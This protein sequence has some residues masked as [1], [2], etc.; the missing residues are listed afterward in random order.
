[1]ITSMK[2]ITVYG[3]AKDRK[4]IMESLQKSGCVEI[5]QS[6]ID[7]ETLT[8]VDVSDQ[9][10]QFERYI[11]SAAQAL[12][13]LDEYVPEKTGLFS[14]RKPISL[15]Y[16]TMN[17]EEAKSVGD[18]VFEIIALSK[19][20]QENKINIGRIQAKILALEPWLGL[21]VPMNL[22]H[23]KLTKIGLY[24]L[25][26]EAD[27]EKMD[28][29]LG[30]TAE[31]VYYEL[32]YCTK[33]QSC[34]FMVYLKQEE[35]RVEKAL[36]EAG[37]VQP[38]FSLSHR[39]PQDKVAHLEQDAKI[40][41]DEIAD[42]E[43]RIIEYGQKR[44]SIKLLYD[45]II[46]RRDKYRELSK[47]QLTK[48]AF[49]LT[50]FIPQKYSEKMKQRLEQKAVCEVMLEDL[51][52][53]EEA[54]VLFE[55]NGFAAPVETITKTYAMPSKNDIDPN[56]IMS[57]FYYLFFGMMFSDAG[58]GILVVIVTGYLA[59]FSHAE[60]STKKTMKMFF[61]CGISTTFWGLMYGSFFGNVVN[62]V[63][64]TFFGQEVALKPLWLDPV[65][66]PLTLLIF[67]VALGMIQIII[68]LSI[69]F[70]MLWRQG[71]KLDAVFDVGFW[72]VLLLGACV[73][74]AGGGLGLS[75]MLQVG[76]W[77]L[78]A[79]AVG[80]VLTQGR[81]K[82]NIFAKFFGGI[83][84]LYDITSYVSD[85]LSYS[86]LMALGLATG[87]IAQVV[88]TMGTLAGGTVQGAII[89]VLIF[90]VGHGMNFAINML[91]AYVHTNRLQYVELFSKFYE[92][93][94]REFAP[95][96]MNTK[97]YMFTED[98]KV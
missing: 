67:S 66:D 34:I 6:Q 26:F 57:F 65:K 22:D 11:S 21:D 15:D 18:D 30:Q 96:A 54:P 25:P 52:D 64:L 82:K 86:R 42:M 89:F 92:G 1:M 93:G 17:P 97:Y 45:H 59:F 7:D 50:G 75:A 71:K 58:Y 40:L 51:T 74:A 46:L 61:F 85:A 94:G 43:G 98:E 36:R 4:T 69:K 8:R 41:E 44:E 37:F 48:E 32:I 79:A 91:G 83:I 3:I 9:I 81:D 84:S 68:G 16:Y 55:N 88:N 5:N 27:A 24:Q 35:E 76:I 47:L 53:E 12:D 38:S 70:Y 56:L 13:I 31:L 90:I 78:V 20:I 23:T 63:S 77:M 60:Q 80:L 95:L 29:L 19:K 33:D 14:A 10:L 49:I 2:K 28:E 72:I 87:V 62:T 39:I 73:L